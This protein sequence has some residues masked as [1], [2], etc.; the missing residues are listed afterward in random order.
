MTINN[1]I[2][3][4]FV[5]GIKD[6]EVRTAVQLAHHKTIKEAVAHVLEVEAVRREPRS[7]R[8]REVVEVVGQVKTAGAGTLGPK[9]YRCDER[10]HIRLNCS[11]RVGPKCYRCGERGHIRI[12]C[13][14]RIEA[15]QSWRQLP[16]RSDRAVSGNEQSRVGEPVWG[17]SNSLNVQTDLQRAKAR[18]TTAEATAQKLKE[19]MDKVKQEA[20]KHKRE[21]EKVKQ[22]AQKWKEEVKKV[23]QEAEKQKQQFS[24]EFTSLKAELSSLKEQ[25]GAQL[26]QRRLPSAQN[27]LPSNEEQ[28]K[29][30]GMI[31]ALRVELEDAA[32]Y[33]AEQR[34]RL[35]EMQDKLR[36]YQDKNNEV[37]AEAQND[38]EKHLSVPDNIDEPRERL[39][40]HGQAS[41]ERMET[42]C[43]RN[44]NHSSFSERTLVWLH[45]PMRR[46][47]KS[48]KLQRR[49]EGPYKVVTRI[50]DVTYRI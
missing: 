19:E 37:V 32:S 39:R 20:E 15:P 31:R 38:A 46:K 47:G 26:K 22:E 23:N 4:A 50:I 18:A 7:G 14:Q 10:G 36:R 9:C 2:L 3:E 30:D 33:S 45:N 29:V 11:Q 5:D 13:R 42:G 24:S 43:D 27:G 6:L 34:D 28:H 40:E 16:A 44:A 1:S 25:L 35:I 48:P 12:D 41:R 17:R 8:L 21:M 49:W